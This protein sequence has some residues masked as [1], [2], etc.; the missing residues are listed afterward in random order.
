ML[1][2]DVIDQMKEFAT[3]N[4]EI[5]G[6]AILGSHARGDAGPK[7][8]LDLVLFVPKATPEKILSE[9][10]DFLFPLNAFVIKA[11]TKKGTIHTA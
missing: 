1:T 2:H 9:T 5:E 4:N 10:A 6:L 7:A 11:N 3:S 8:D